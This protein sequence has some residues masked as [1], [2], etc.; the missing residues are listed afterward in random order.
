LIAAR[1]GK[2]V[3]MIALTAVFFGLSSC[4][5]GLPGSLAPPGAVSAST[6]QIEQ[7]TVTWDTVPHA[8]RY[9]L[10]R[11]QDALGPFWVEGAFGPIP[12]ATVVDPPFVDGPLDAGTLYYRVTAVQLFT[13]TES[14]P[15]EV[16][17][18]VSLPGPLEWQAPA[19]IPG[20]LTTFGTVRVVVDQES[21]VVRGYVF[22]IPDDGEAAATVR[23]VGVDGSLYTVGAPFGT[24]DGTDLGSGDLAV[25]AGRIIVALVGETDDAVSVWNYDAGADQFAVLSTGLP[26]AHPTAPRVS[27]AALSTE[28][29]LLAYRGADN[30]LVAYEIDGGVPVTLAAPID[31]SESVIGGLAIAASGDAAV[32]GVEIQDAVAVTTE[33]VVSNW[34]GT[35]WGTPISLAG[36]V[37]GNVSRIDATLDPSDNTPY[38]AYQDET[39]VVIHDTT[40]IVGSSSDVGFAGTPVSGGPIAVAADNATVHLFYED[41]P[42]ASGMIRSY[43]GASWSEFSPADFTEGDGLDAVSTAAAGGKLFTAYIRDGGAVVRVYQ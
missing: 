22:T 36:D 31:T 23:G 14:A 15:S 25:A 43:D 39:G 27:L 21:S 1:S 13:G 7:I 17:A 5:L 18:G 6:D 26:A 30:A 3:G 42:A 20:F 19:T 38:L 32:L 12:Y 28:H 40:A 10:Y 33:L 41:G 9:Y 8:D 16:A 34:S 2:V 35:S 4:G 37:T 11:S 24:T 29:F